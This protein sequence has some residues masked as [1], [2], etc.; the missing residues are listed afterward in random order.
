MEY[1]IT[2]LEG[3][4]SFVSPC[5]LPM[6][7]LYISYFSGNTE[8][9]NR[10]TFAR[11]IAFVCG[12]TLVFCLM[13]FLAGTVG[14]LLI[15]YEKI[16]NIICGIIVI[17]F[18]LNYLDIIKLPFLKGTGKFIEVKNIFSAFLFGII[19]SINITPCT[20][21]FL[22]SALMMASASQTFLKGIILL[23]T[24]SLGLG[25]PLIISAILIEKL[26]TTFTFIKK[27][28]KIINII[29]GSFLIIIGVLMSFGI[30]I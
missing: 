1:I 12:F 5:M 22:G 13:G 29:S 11:V 15:R 6:I 4:I 20:G 18:G 10:K 27:H 7:P 21:A 28:Y 8:E 25:V 30:M 2:F 17:L 3:I 16:I 26:K 14:N 23:F 24:Y 19:F 9:K